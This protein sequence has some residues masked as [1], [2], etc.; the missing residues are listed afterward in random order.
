LDDLDEVVESG[1]ALGGAGGEDGPDAFGSL[2]SA[3]AA[4]S[5]GD[6]PVDGHEAE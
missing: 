4:G 6:A 1:A 5:L 2:A 3:L